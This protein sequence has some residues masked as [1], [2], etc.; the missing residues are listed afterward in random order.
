VTADVNLGG[1]PIAAA[2]A[3]SALWILTC[4]RACSGLQPSSGELVQVAVGSGRVI[5]R[6][7]VADP[8]ALTISGGAI[9]IAHFVTGI[10]TRVDPAT[11]QTTATIRLTL[12]GPEIFGD[13]SFLPFGISAGDGRIW[14]TTVRGWLAVIDSRTS[15]LVAMVPTP[16]ESSGQAVVSTSG[17]W[18]TESLAGVGFLA[19]NGRRLASRQISDAG[20]DVDVAGVA[21]GGGLVWA[22][23]S[24]FNPASSPGQNDT[25]VVTAIDPRTG[26]IVRQ[27]RIAGPDDSFAYG[28]GA[29]YAADFQSGLVQRITPDF[30]V[31]TVPATRGSESLAAATAGALWA[32]T[33]SGR[34]L[35]IITPQ[36]RSGVFHAIAWNVS[37]ETPGSSCAVRLNPGGSR[38]T[39]SLR[40]K[41]PDAP[42]AGGVGPV[43]HS[44][45]AGRREP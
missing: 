9:W 13:R 21:V 8:Q 45:L 24:F 18:V 33:E 35:R 2:A 15:R 11:G 3:R 31:Q 22:Y 36:R 16:A 44:W 14:V 6:F 38:Q 29:L 30:R 23:G 4:V 28:N 32:T 26:T 37:A 34:L 20:Q 12:P 27:L 19:P 17:T 10:I 1:V 42:C 40:A 43:D 41:L 7:P 5:R 39:W 25:G